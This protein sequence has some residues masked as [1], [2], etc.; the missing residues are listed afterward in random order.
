[1]PQ[2]LYDDSYLADVLHEGVIRGNVRLRRG[3]P[4]ELVTTFADDFVIGVVPA[5][6][7]PGV[8]EEMGDR[9]SDPN[10]VDVL[11]E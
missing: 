2:A 1:M 5:A 8:C 6:R 7:F 11:A 3:S 10:A 4:S 9:V